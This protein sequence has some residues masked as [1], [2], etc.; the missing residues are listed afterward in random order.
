MDR[1]ADID[2]IRSLCSFEGRLAGTDA[3]RRA[4]NEIAQRLRDAGRRVEIEPIHVRPQVWTGY[5][6]HCL[7]GIAGSIASIAIA[8]LGFGLALF[9]ATSLYLDL[10]GRFLVLRRILFRRGSQNVLS[11]GKH[12]DAPG[13]VI[14]SAH[15]DVA[16]TGYL[17]GARIRALRKLV[18]ARMGAALSPSRLMFWSLATLVPLLGARMTGFEPAWLA[19]LQLLPTLV[20]VVAT[21]LLVDIQLSEPVP[22]AGDNAAGVAAALSIADAL[23]HEPPAHLDVWLLLTGGG[24][25]GMEGMRSFVRAQNHELDRA[26]TYFLILD[27]P[28]GDQLRCVASEGLAVSYRHDARLSELCEA[29]AAVKANEPGDTDFAVAYAPIATD[30]L[31]A[32]LA[33]YPAIALA[34]F[35]EDGLRRPEHHTAEDVPARVNHDALEHVE[36]FGLELVRKIDDELER[37]LSARQSEAR[38]RNPAQA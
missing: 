2:L 22:G 16:R 10:N 11:R 36:S 23:E 24:E 18:P 31:P 7:L 38:A 19:T 32:T 29:I 13:Q 3:E 6:L 35:G 17:Y 20:L 4:A 15:I 30:A 25:S 26:N 28:I 8:P 1:A 5:A 12:P 14:L 37:L 34:G 9:A 33:G 21:F 27:E